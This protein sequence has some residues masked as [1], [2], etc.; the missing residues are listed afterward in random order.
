MD[1]AY[2][3]LW[4]TQVLGEISDLSCRELVHTLNHGRF[5]LIAAGLN[6]GNLIG[7]LE[8][9]GY[10]ST[11][12]KGKYGGTYE[13]MFMVHDPRERDMLILAERYKQHAVVLADNGVY[14]LVT[15]FGPNKGQ[16]RYG[17][18]WSIVAGMEGNF[19]QVE[20]SDGETIRFRL[21]V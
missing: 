20:T 19:T 18:G 14:R 12:A 9:A 6:T 5:A 16:V 13:P 4:K 8:S 15:T 17:S 11:P 1:L 3:L 10:R 7:V 21:E 2:K